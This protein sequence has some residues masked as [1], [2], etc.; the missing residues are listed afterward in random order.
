MTSFGHRVFSSFLVIVWLSAMA[1]VVF[2]GGEYYST[3]LQE[4][5]FSEFHD[6]YK[7][8]GNV[9]HGLGVVG[10][11]LIV[12]G[13][14]AYSLRKRVNF[15]TNAGRLRTWLMVHI[16][17]CTLGPAFVLFHTSFKFGGIVSIAF[18]SMTVV[19]LSGIFGRYLYGR[20]PKTIQGRFRSVESVRKQAAEV[21]ETVSEEF[22]LSSE[23]TKA[24]LPR[25][26][27][28]RARGFLHALVLALRYDFSRRFLK[29]R[30]RKL[31]AQTLAG[32]GTTRGNMQALDIP[33][34]R[35]D[36][37]VQLLQSRLLLEQQIVLL[38]PF[39]RLFGY[40]HILHLPLAAVMFVIMIVHIAISVM[41]GYTWVL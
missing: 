30:V 26:Q 2:Q 33:S 39:Q 40:W 19:A 16:F 27:R 10:S 12:L 37:M 34:D 20:V 28:V 32:S 11:T 23:Q 4:R 3:P 14:G 29:K 38:E 15:L 41:F 21:I 35:R 22:G 31:L 8:S 13:V 36:E 25:S 24:L 18:W 7:P 1:I 9:G 6:L 17:L 5:P